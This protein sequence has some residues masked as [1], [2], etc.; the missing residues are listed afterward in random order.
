MKKYTIVNDEQLDDKL[1]EA[2]D[3]IRSRT[4]KTEKLD[5]LAGDFKTEVEELVNKEDYLAAVMNRQCTELVNTKMTGTAPKE[6]QN[7]NK[8]LTRVDLPNITK[9]D[10]NAF[11]S[12]TNLTSVKF[13]KVTET[14]GGA[15]SGTAITSLYMPALER[16]TG[17]GYD[18]SSCTKL[19]KAYFPKLTVLTGYALAGNGNMTTLIFGAG[20]V[21]SIASTTLNNTAIAYGTGYVYVPKS[22]VDSYKT[23]SVWSAYANQIIAIEDSPEVLNGWE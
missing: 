15:I 23:N 12:C 13:P 11:A 18:F 4:G 10:S 8:N 19:T 9:L 6:W 2:A 16:V 21:C 22:L 20:Q 1:K 5:F 7:G 3:A 14:A 17:W